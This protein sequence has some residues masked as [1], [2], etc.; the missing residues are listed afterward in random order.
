MPVFSFALSKLQNVK[1][2]TIRKKQLTGKYFLV[3]FVFV[4][5]LYF[6]LLRPGSE[7]IARFYQKRVP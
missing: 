2:A 5:F 4:F 1:A 3:E 7:K 6:V